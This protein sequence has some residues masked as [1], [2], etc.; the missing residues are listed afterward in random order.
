[1]PLTTTS[2]AALGD[3]ARELHEIC[4]TPAE[5]A[6]TEI[7]HALSTSGPLEPKRQLHWPDAASRL[8]D[9]LTLVWEAPLAPSWPLTR[10]VLERDSLR[11][12]R[13]LTRGGLTALFAD[14]TPLITLAEQAPA[15]PAG[16]GDDARTEFSAPPPANRPDAAPV[17]AGAPRP[18]PFQRDSRASFE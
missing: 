15:G 2:E 17:D 4:A 7:E 3:I 13:S 1:L 11:R 14:L 16:P 5:R 8:A 18:G 12:S 9:L 10:G 6:R